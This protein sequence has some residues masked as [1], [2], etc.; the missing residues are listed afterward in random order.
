MLSVLS[1]SSPARSLIGLR[2]VEQVFGGMPAL[3]ATD[4]ELRAGELIALLGPSGCG[5]TTLLRILAGLIQP[6]RGTVERPGVAVES[7][8]IFQRPVLLP[9]RS[10]LANTLLPVE[11]RRR[12]TATDRDRAHDLLEMVGLKGFERSRPDQ[13]SG[14]MQQRVAL[15]RALMLRPRIL[16]LDE[17]FAAL[18]EFTR[19][20]MNL[21]LLRI[22]ELKTE[23]E[24]SVIVTHSLEEAVFLA[25]RVVVLSGRPGRVLDT[26]PVPLA[27]PRTLEIKD[28]EV[29]H[30]CTA[31][32][33]HLLRSGVP[34]RR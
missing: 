33:R 17:P 2:E 13:L 10:A 34:S 12:V 14:G 7:G 9:W 3:A 22:F 19:E 26:V 30:S 4:L 28:E 27:R 8:F 11:L 15:A 32:L 24:A 18:D 5:K 16:F 21:E 25:D 23:L 1:A 20:D 29:F 31:H 6:T